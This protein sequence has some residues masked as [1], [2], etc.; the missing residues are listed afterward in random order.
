M[1][2]SV[3]GVPG[4]NSPHPPVAQ[5][6]RGCR[7]TPGLTTEQPVPPGSAPRSQQRLTHLGLTVVSQYPVPLYLGAGR[8]VCRV[9]AWEAA[10]RRCE[11][12][13]P[14]SS[15]GLPRCM[16]GS[17]EQPRAASSTTLQECAE[18]YCLMLVKHLGYKC[19]V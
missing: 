15:C 11:R 5:R 4:G 9:V 16:R 6:G 18:D 19:Q 2:V 7:N 12:L 8:T 17:K 14:E 3:G 13:P 10:G 1:H